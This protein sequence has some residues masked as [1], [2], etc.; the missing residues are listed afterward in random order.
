MN[1]WATFPGHIL[2]CLGGGIIKNRQ[3]HCVPFLGCYSLQCI[4]MSGSKLSCKV[5]GPYRDLVII[6]PSYR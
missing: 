6:F 2:Q 4:F 1:S 5:P 3:C